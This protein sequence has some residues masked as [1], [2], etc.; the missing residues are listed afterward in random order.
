MTIADQIRDEKLQYCINREDAKISALSSNKIGKYE[1]LT[2][3]EILPSNQKQIIEQAKFTYSPL[4]KAFEKQI[5]TIEDKGQKQI[6]AL[7]SLKPKEQTKSIEEMFLEGYDSAEIKNELNKIKEYEK[8]VNRDNMIYY[9]SKEP[10]DFRM[11]KTIRS[12]GDDIYSSKITINE[13]DQEQS[14]LVEYILNFNNKTRPKNKD[15]KKKQKK[16]FFIAHKIFI[17]V[18]N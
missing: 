17:M 14:D 12:F 8:K 3:E 11:F 18:E 4:G 5:K 6:D 2:G 13:A 15:D 10:F 1:Y 7:E 9:S 16:I